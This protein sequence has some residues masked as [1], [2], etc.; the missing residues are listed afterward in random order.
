MTNQRRVVANQPAQEE[1]E[2]DPYAQAE[3]RKI[4]NWTRRKL[5]WLHSLQRKQQQRT[6]PARNSKKVQIR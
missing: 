3:L 6:V 1:W 5:A 4:A 2:L